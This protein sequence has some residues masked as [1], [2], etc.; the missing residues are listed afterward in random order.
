[1]R[2]LFYNALFFTGT[3]LI[4]NRVLIINKDRIEGFADKDSAP[5]DTVRVDCEGSLVTAGMVDLQIAGGGGCLFSSD[6][7]P[8]A[9]ELIASSIVGTGTTGFL[10]ALPTNTEE[11]Y[12]AAF[13][14]IRES[15]HPA[16]MG[17]H[18]EGPFISNEKRGAHAPELIRK[19]SAANV[20]A[21]LAE[22]GNVIRMM[23]VARRNVRR[24][25]LPC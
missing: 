23:T 3:E 21:L 20:A 15:S 22:A 8:E 12:R 5:A 24:I 19:P 10:L 25:S 11:V 17:L 2:T 18:M 4:D 6:P 14:T 13:H 1:M 9:L 7:S 16:V